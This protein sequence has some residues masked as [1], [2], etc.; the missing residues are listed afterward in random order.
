MS[1]I[2][3]K[4][5]TQI[6]FEDRNSLRAHPAQHL[7]T[8]IR[9]QNLCQVIGMSYIRIFQRNL[10]G[11][12]MSMGFGGSPTQVGVLTLCDLGHVWKAQWLA[13]SKSPPSAC[14]FTA[15]GISGLSH[16][17]RSIPP[18]PIHC[19]K[20]WRGTTSPPNHTSRRTARGGRLLLN[21]KSRVK[22]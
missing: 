5:H 20:C 17:W 1:P 3:S 10:W 22:T 15:I 6:T 8:L 21:H 13:H 2:S 16:R 12:V 19:C 11:V 14:C 7:H 18:V 4:G 9:E